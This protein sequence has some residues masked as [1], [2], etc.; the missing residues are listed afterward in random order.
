MKLLE[1]FDYKRQPNFE[2]GEILLFDKPMLWSS[3]DV[4]KKIRNLI[5]TNLEKTK[6]K[7]VQ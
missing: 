1:A 4:V 6:L 7:V 3:F 5:T 2:E